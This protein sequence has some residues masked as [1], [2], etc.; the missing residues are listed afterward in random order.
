M[1]YKNVN[2]GM[3]RIIELEREGIVHPEVLKKMIHALNLD[4]EMIDKLIRQDK[5]QQEREFQKWVNT[6]IKMHLTIRWMASVYGHC[7]IP[8]EIQS[9]EEAIKYACEKAKE[10]KCMLWLVL[11]RK[12]NIHINNEGQ[13]I[14]R[15]VVTRDRS[16]LPFMALK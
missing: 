16:F 6:P 14:S 7:N 3:R 8:A 11:S 5:E 1:G 9:E 15:N 13:I 10:L 2:R 12:E 4:Q